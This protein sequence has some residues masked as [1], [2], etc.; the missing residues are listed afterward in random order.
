MSEERR[1]RYARG[2][3]A[4]LVGALFMM[5]KGYRIIERRYITRVGELDL[6]A[7]RGRNIL[8]IEVKFRRQIDAAAYAIT[9]RQQQR[10]HRAAQVWL[11]RNDWSRGH[12][13]RF[14]AL[15]VSPWRWP[16]Q[17]ENIIQP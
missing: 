9:P 5:A 6:V 14:D 17:V 2:H 4:E 8:F 3:R 10:L 15:L 12:D 13:L 16:R 11:G 7:K 1:A